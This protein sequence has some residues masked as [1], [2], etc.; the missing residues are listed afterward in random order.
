VVRVPYFPEGIY[1]E[2]SSQTLTW[3]TNGS[4]F[5]EIEPYGPKTFL[6]PGD[7]STMD[8]H[9]W[10]LP[11]SPALAP[12]FDVHEAAAFIL[13]RTDTTAG[14]STG[15]PNGNLLPGHLEKG[16]FRVH[17]NPAISQL[18]ITLERPLERS[19]VIEIHSMNGSL[20]ARYPATDLCTSENAANISVQVLPAGIY[21]IRVVSMTHPP[22]A[23]RFLKY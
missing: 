12:G 22:V 21:T 17:P 9:W 2:D 1:V 11:Y 8:I 20:A 7:S 15:I 23:C 10:L 3:Y 4:Q 18:W 14:D 5:A 16:L 13:G 19:D 6:Q